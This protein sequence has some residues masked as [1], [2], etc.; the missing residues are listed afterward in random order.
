M[1]KSI[2]VR[3]HFMKNI[4]LNKISSGKKVRDNGNNQGSPDLGGCP[5]GN[6]WKIGVIYLHYG[7]F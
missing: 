1:K 6:V 7:G 4:I 2:K 3:I 5:P